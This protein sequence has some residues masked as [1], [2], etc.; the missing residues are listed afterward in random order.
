MAVRE[1]DTT[2]AQHDATA[3][4]RAAVRDVYGDVGVV[5]V[6]TVPR[7]VAGDGE[8]L[9]KVGAAG[10]DRG[11][12]HLMTGL[13]YAGRLAFGLRRPRQP[14][15]GLDLAGTVVA[16]GPGV[17]GL[18]VGD[19]VFGA[20]AGTFAEYATAPVRSL[21]RRPAG[22]SAEQAAV[23]PVSAATALKAVRD[24]GKVS[25]GQRVLVTG[26]AGGVGSYA[27]QLAVSAGAHVTGVASA[28]KAEFVRELGAERVLDY[29]TEDFADGAERY[30]VVIDIAGNPSISRLRRALTPTGTAVVTGGEGGGRVLGMGR[31]VRAVAVSPFV[32]QRLATFVGTVRTAALDDL[33]ALI[34]TGA[35]RPTLERA[36]PLE[37]APAAIASLV[38]GEVRG[39]LAV[40]V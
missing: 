13:P 31:Q 16:L 6:A 37:E 28:A 3:T 2:P 38:A 21:A 29:R 9:V 7:P 5:R 17:T 22:L 18:A 20:G 32:R 23:V 12:W 27:V 36:Y 11:V 34:A 15:L 25:P 1:Q 30:D 4:M 26:A 14:V 19:E 8:V 10:V 39:K 24:I 40:V 33:S 35:L